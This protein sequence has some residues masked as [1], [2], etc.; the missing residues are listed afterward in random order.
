M[1]L[2]LGTALKSQLLSKPTDA[3]IA[4]KHQRQAALMGHVAPGQCDVCFAIEKLGAMLPTGEPLC[5]GCIEDN[6]NEAARVEK[7]LAEGDEYDFSAPYRGEYR[8][9]I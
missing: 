2:Y 8:G 6:A 4:A 3:E 7:A 9:I 5:P 1:S